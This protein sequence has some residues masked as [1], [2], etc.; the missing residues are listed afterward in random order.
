MSGN[1]IDR[2]TSTFQSGFV[3]VMTAMALFSLAFDVF[4]LIKAN[5][6]AREARIN[7][8]Q[9]EHNRREMERSGRQIDEV[10]SKILRDAGPPC[11]GPAVPDGDAP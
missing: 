1:E 11:R 4:T 10:R 7:S 3:A 8:D 2:S 5:E 9:L 6:A